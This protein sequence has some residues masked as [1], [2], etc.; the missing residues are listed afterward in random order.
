MRSS[1]W[2]YVCFTT[3]KRVGVL[4]DR[5]VDLTINDYPPLIPV[6]VLRNDH[7]NVGFHEQHLAR[8]ALQ[9]PTPESVERQVSLWKCTNEFWPLG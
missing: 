1:A 3:R 4:S 6:R 5:Q 8:L 2:N 9:K 7:F